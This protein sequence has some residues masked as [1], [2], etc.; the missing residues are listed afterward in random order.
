MAYTVDQ[1]AKAIAIINRHDGQVTAEALGY[2]QAIRGLKNVTKVTVLRWLKE[3][4][5][6]KN[7]TENTPENVPNV[8][9]KKRPVTQA[10]IDAAEVALD[11]LFEKVARKYLGHALNSEVVK[12]TKGKEAVIAAATATD[13]MRLLR[14][15]PTEIVSILPEVLEALQR[16]G[17]NP[18]DVL[19]RLKEAANGSI[20][21]QAHLH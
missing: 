6:P 19:L 11:D 20:S 4:E 13:K 7:V 9:E 3:A 12:E 2:I 17:K 18:Y 10:D 8:T 16:A 1:K 14:N 5:L 15:L 21:D